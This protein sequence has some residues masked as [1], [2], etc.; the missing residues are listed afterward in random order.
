MPV[1]VVLELEEVDVVV[2]EEL[3]AVTFDEEVS[4]IFVTFCGCVQILTRNRVC[5]CVQRTLASASVL[6]P[7]ESSGFVSVEPP[8]T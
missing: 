4:A 5:E 6:P 8:V 1:L 2:D 3:V 7:L